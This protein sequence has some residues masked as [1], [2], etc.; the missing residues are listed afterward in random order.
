MATHKEAS[1]SRSQQ[2]VD[3]YSSKRRDSKE[4]RRYYNE[5]LGSI[6]QFMLVSGLTEQEIQQ[7]CSSALNA[8]ARARKRR[9]ERDRSSIRV[10]GSML[11][12]W[13]RDKRYLD[14]DANPLAIP[15]HGPAPS[16]EALL[17]SEEPGSTVST[18]VSQLKKWRLIR[19]C[20]SR[21][22]KPVGT[23]VIY[24]QLT[25]D[26]IQH[27]ASAMANL[28][29]TVEYNLGIEDTRE[30]LIERSAI[31]TDLPKRHARA[32]RE[33]T[34][35][36]GAAIINTINDWLESR[37]CSRKSRSG[38]QTIAVGLHTYAYVRQPAK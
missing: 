13:H 28:L 15:V 21:L 26:V 35:E 11:Y 22:Y 10:H 6:L 9:R 14:R 30:A 4:I 23:D 24:R 16:I 18:T 27:I 33:F 8:A 20:G 3:E 12:K 36:Q 38:G 7:C 2:V 31:V 32:F 25:P 5:V 29:A 17:R 34:H 19:R 1:N 37:R